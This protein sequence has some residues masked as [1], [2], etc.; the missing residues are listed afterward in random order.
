MNFREEIQNMLRLTEKMTPI[1][2]NRIIFAISTIGLLIGK[3][4]LLE[5]SHN[6]VIDLEEF[7][8]KAYLYID[9]KQGKEVLSIALSFLPHKIETFMF[10]NVIEIITKFDLKHIVL[11]LGINSDSSVRN[12]VFSISSIEWINSLVSE[13]FKTHGDIVSIIV[14]VELLILYCICSIIII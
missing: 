3:E 5:I 11:D 12:E 9:D 14:I 10:V 8:R 7:S 2:S 1:E 13:I 6:T 4:N